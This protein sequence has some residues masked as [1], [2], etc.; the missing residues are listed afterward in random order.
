VQIEPPPAAR[1]AF[2]SVPRARAPIRAR[3][4]TGGAGGGLVD[5]HAEVVEIDPSEQQVHVGDGQRAAPPVARRTGIGARALGT[6]PKATL[7]VDGADRAA[8]GGDGVD[9]HAR[10]GER[11]GGDPGSRGD[12]HRAVDPDHVGAGAAHVEADHGAETEALRHCGDADGTARRPAQQALRRAVAIRLD[13]A[14]G[15]GERKHRRRFV[16]RGDRADEVADLRVERGVDDGGLG[17]F[18][19]SGVPGEIGRTDHPPKARRC[20]HRP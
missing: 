3:H 7:A 12:R 8:T 16:G 20:K 2:G 1:V 6:D 9:R 19:Q 18:E 11:G 4:A 5:R 14:A 13:E 17:P 15:A 10:R